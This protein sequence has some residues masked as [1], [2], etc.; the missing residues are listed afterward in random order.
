MTLFMSIKIIMV[1]EFFTAKF[2]NQ[3][4]LDMLLSKMFVQFIEVFEQA[5][6]LQ[7]WTLDTPSFRFLSVYP[8]MIFQFSYRGKSFQTFCATVGPFY[9]GWFLFDVRWITGLMELGSWWNVQPGSRPN[10]CYRKSGPRDKI[11]VYNYGRLSDVGAWLPIKNS[12]WCSDLHWDELWPQ[13]RSNIRKTLKL[14]AG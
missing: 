2:T 5:L 11:W 7:A 9:H 8:L 6:A 13:T 12:C 3:V 10:V 4:Q 1:D 14:V